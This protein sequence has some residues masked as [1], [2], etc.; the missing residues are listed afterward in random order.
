MDVIIVPSYE[1]LAELGANLI[2]ELL[3]EKPSAVLGLATGYTPIAIYQR[4]IKSYQRGDLSF[5]GVTTFNL[6]E[7]YGCVARR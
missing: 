4:L 5:K 1:D 6:D 3:I 7:Y 2:A